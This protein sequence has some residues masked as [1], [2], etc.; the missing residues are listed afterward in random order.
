MAMSSLGPL[1]GTQGLRGRLRRGVLN[2]VLGYFALT[3]FAPTGF[4]PTGFT[5]IGATDLDALVRLLSDLPPGVSDIGNAAKLARAMAD[6]LKAAVA[7]FPLFAAPGQPLDPRLLFTASASGK[8]RVSVINLSGLPSDEGRQDFVNQLQ[9]ALFAFIKR[10]PAPAGRKLTG[11]YVM[12]EAQVFAPSQAATACK[13]STIALAAQARKYGL[14]MLF[15]TQVPKNIDNKIINNCTTHL[16]GKM[17]S[18]ASIQATLDLIQSRGGAGNDIGTLKTGQFYLATE[19]MAAPERIKTTLCL[20]HH[21]SAPLTPQE[22][23]Q[24]ARSSRA[25]VAPPAGAAA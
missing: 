25:V 17:S 6:E 9:M 24:R 20:S 23:L 15:A 19:G 16:Y 10:N 11:L 14:G 8:T 22:V 18:P 5:P 3:G 12:D 2:Q 13:D 7:S 1:V 4:T 21:P